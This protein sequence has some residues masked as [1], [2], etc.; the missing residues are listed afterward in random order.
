MSPA[1][2]S[3]VRENHLRADELIYPIFVMEGQNLCSPVE[4]MPG[5]C[6]YS[7]DRLP[8]ELDRVVE[9]GI[10]SVLLFG[11]PAHKDEVG[12]GAYDDQGIV[13]RAIRFIKSQERYRHLI[14]IADVCLCEYTSHGHC[15]LVKDGVILNDET[16]PLLAR[17]AV[18]Y[19]GAG[20]DMVAPSDM[21]D[22]RVRAIR[23][24]LDE[25]GFVQ[26]PI[27]AYSAKFA[28][29][30]YGPFRDAAHSAPGFGDRKTYQMDSANGREALREVEEDLREGADLIIAKPA[31]AYMDIIRNITEAFHVPVAAY[32][33]SGEYAMVKA[34]A[35]NGWIDEK[36]IVMEILVGLK[37]AGAKMIITYHALD[38]AK[39]IR[40]GE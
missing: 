22:G 3:L 25:H 8:E 23:E 18:S 15:G 37:R 40:E 20:A 1:M 9:G 38:A 31:M 32:N 30:F 21:M 2:R 4:S 35:A 34:A 33:V 28:S 6:Q 36:K 19:A 13:Q 17:T 14:V 11:I 7:I 29:G 12:S 27:M 24:A 10:L 5:I 16:L 39:W 26:I